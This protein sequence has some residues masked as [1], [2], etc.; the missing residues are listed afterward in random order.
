MFLN[1]FRSIL[2]PLLILSFQ[3]TILSSQASEDEC[4]KEGLGITS[5]RK[6]I[7][8]KGAASRRHFGD[9]KKYSKQITIIANETDNLFT[10]AYEETQSNETPFDTLKFYKCRISKKFIN[11]VLQGL[12]HRFHGHE[13]VYFQ[14]C[15]LK[16]I[17]K[18]KVRE[19]V[20]KELGI[21]KIFFN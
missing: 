6:S 13:A 17:N 14:E 11:D 21:S 19:I 12:A 3:A 18:Q 16:D 5:E 4:E 8:I 10:K 2:F 15:V 1:F 9:A 7:V 20:T